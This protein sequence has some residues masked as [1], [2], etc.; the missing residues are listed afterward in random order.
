MSTNASYVSVGKPKVTGAVHR[1]PLGTPLPTTATEPLNEA[2]K[3]MGY[4]SDEGWTN[5]KSRESSEIKAWGGDTVLQPQTSK[6]D[7]FKLK[8]IESL[9]PETIKA[10]QGDDNVEG[11]LATG[12]TVRENSQELPRASWVIDTI[13]TGGVIKRTIIPEGQITELGDVVHKDDEPI[14]YDTII[15]AYPHAAYDGDTHRELYM[16]GSEDGGK[17]LGTLTVSSEAGS[18]TGKTTVTVIPAKEVGKIYK[19]KLAAEAQTV[20]YDSNV[21]NWT[22]WDG[23]AEIEAEAGQVITIVEATADYKAR[24]AGSATVTINA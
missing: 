10:V 9:N 24:K 22:A 2:F 1:A 18:Q 17:T 5:S 11:N 21:Q 23:E 14:G 20:D 4:I 16:G 15:T 3:D 8:F 6:T 19:I 13:L 12:L 7:T